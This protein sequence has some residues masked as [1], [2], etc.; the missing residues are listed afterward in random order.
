MLNADPR[1]P[2]KSS[3]L[4]QLIKSSLYNF[5]PKIKKALTEEIKNIFNSVN[6]P[7]LRTEARALLNNNKLLSRFGLNKAITGPFAKVIQAEIGQQMWNDITNFRQHREGTQE[8][9]KA[10]EQLV[11]PEF[12]PIFNEA[13]K[14]IQYSKQNQW[15]KAKEVFGIADN[16]AWDHKIPSSIIDKGYA[17]IIEYT[18]VKIKFVSRENPKEDLI[19]LKKDMLTSDFTPDHKHIRVSGLKS[20]KFKPETLTRI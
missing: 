9:L 11:A 4:K 10:F 1:T 5:N 16:I 15:A 17:D 13:A 7:K 20:V 3:H 12:K 18:K 14:A 19:Q 2:I 8:M 6:L